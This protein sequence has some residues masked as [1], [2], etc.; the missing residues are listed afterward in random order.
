MKSNPVPADL[1]IKNRSKLKSKLEPGSLAVICSGKRMPRNGDQFYPFRQQSDFFYLTGIGREGFV[2]FLAPDHPA[3]DLREVLLMQDQSGKDRLWFGPGL[4]AEE[5][6]AL[7]GISHIRDMDEMD[8]IIA[9]L[10]PRAA[11][12]CFNFPDIQAAS[13]RVSIFDSEIYTTITSR[14]PRVKPARLSPLLTE[15]RMIKEPEEVDEIR[16]A[17]AITAS[18]FKKALS[19]IRPGVR[20]YEVEAEIIAEFIRAGAE[21]PAFD[22]IVACGENA[23]I[24]HYVENRRKCAD[25]AL[26][27]MD[28]GAEVNNY[29][30][31]CSRTVPVRGSFTGR[32]RELYDTVRKIFMQARDLMQTGINLETLHREVGALW[33]EEHIRLGLYTREEAGRQDPAE[34][35]WKNYFPHGLSHSIGL[36]V[37]DPFERDI[38]LQPGMVLSCEPAIYIPEER[39]GI[40]LENVILISEKGAEDLM[41]DIPME[42]PDIERLMKHNSD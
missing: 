1:F 33:Q 37:H 22:P 9:A 38:P 20:E 19:V 24:L 8:R 15:L 29:A 34:P 31:D 41:E 21:G 40:R 25:D 11:T 32:Q 3:E 14:Y 2:L 6:S 4:T 27:L 7:S 35:L 39:L 17:C 12:I 28:F 18:A 10:V 16:K 13:P 5:V 30:A 26:L 42:A 36:D 23:L